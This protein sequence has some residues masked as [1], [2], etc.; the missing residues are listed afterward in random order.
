M[1]VEIIGTNLTLS[2]GSWRLRFVLALEDTDDA[3]KEKVRPPHRLRVVPE[4]EYV[5]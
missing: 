5:R 3:P 1:I 4:D 2:L